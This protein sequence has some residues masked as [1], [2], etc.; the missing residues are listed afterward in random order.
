MEQVLDISA[1]G[2]HRQLLQYLADL[3]PPGGHMMVEY[4]SLEQQAAA[5]SLA[6][7]SP[8]I[9]TPLGYMLFLVGCGT[10]FKDWH[11]AEGGSE[12]PRKL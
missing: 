1:N 8:P 9:L 5:R 4:D 3:I 10:S 7:G 2:L 6:L 11:F 12:G